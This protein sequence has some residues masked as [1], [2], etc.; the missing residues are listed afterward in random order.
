MFTTDMLNLRN[1]VKA[2]YG[3]LLAM[4]FVRHQCL[5][6]NKILDLMG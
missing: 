1:Y 6:R 2:F 4:Y 5:I 3:Q